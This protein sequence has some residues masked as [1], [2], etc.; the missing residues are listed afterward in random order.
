MLGPDFFGA[1]TAIEL[2]PRSFCRDNKPQD[3]GF[4]D[5]VIP[6]QYVVKITTNVATDLPAPPLCS[7]QPG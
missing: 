1:D 4:K 3:Y 7:S 2:A 6:E 5:N